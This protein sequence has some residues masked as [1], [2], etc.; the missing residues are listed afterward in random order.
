MK[1]DFI[2]RTE[3]QKAAFENGFRVERPGQDFW[4]CFASA[5]APG[6]VWLSADSSNGPWHLAVT[7]VGVSLELAWPRTSSGPGEA[8]M[9]FAS[10]TELYGGLERVYRLSISLPDMPLVEFN[11]KTSSLPRSTEIERLVVQRIGQD[12]FRAALLDYWGGH[13]PLTGI[14]DRA[15][16]RASHIV[17][18]AHCDDDAHRLDVH[19]GLLLSALWDAAFDAGK[20]SFSDAGGILVHP[21]LSLP[22]SEHLLRSGRPLLSGLKPQHLLNLA[23][24]RQRYGFN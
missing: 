21:T 15:L 11:K 4:L 24:H 23:R 19:N 3:L 18:W 2:A 16:L 22:D 10:L 14:S 20:V 13:C 8:A 12:V 1:L 9:Q 17:G 5:T 7:H 6:E